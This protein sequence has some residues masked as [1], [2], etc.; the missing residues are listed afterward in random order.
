MKEHSLVEPE[1]AVLSW[2]LI[3]PVPAQLA[4]LGVDVLSRLEGLRPLSGG[5]VVSSYGGTRGLVE[6]VS[7]H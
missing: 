5:A 7:A 1:P 2:L 6:A 3:D 4:S